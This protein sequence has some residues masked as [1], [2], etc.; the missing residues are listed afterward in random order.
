MKND[1]NLVSYEVKPHFREISYFDAIFVITYKLSR[2][3]K[4]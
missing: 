4:I 1:Q 3:I 2:I